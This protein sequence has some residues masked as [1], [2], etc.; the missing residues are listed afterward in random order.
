MERARQAAEEHAAA[1]QGTGER[2]RA[3]FA[4]VAGTV[5]RHDGHLLDEWELSFAQNF[6]VD[7]ACLVPLGRTMDRSNALLP[8][9]ACLPQ[10]HFAWV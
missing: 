4:T 6:E 8:C 2:L 7:D 1:H 5:L 9:L 3:N 10:S